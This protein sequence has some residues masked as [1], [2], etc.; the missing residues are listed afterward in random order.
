[1]RAILS[2]V[3]STL[4]G[5]IV[6]LLPIGI[7]L[8]VL[9]KLYGWARNAGDI[10]HKAVFPA[11]E[12]RLVPFLIA[13][14]VLF[15]IAF[16]AG[17]FART[18]LGTSIFMRLEGAVLARLPVYT[19]FRTMIGDMAGGSAMLSG[20]A[21][22]DVVTVRFD[23]HTAL[24]FLIE[25]RADGTAVV[26]LPGAPSVLSGS[27]VMVEQDRLAATALSPADVMTG[28]RRLGAGLGRLSRR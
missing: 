13:V 8:V 21:Q 12:G 23:D 10:L 14:A 9:G 24:G 16:V 17:A 18:R 19:L 7:V 15:L 3:K 26:Y 5:G 2:A 6:F 20:G 22:A 25:R 11:S 4:V 1:M 27:V 28:F